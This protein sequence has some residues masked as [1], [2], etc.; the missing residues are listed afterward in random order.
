MSDF[1]D[2]FGQLSIPTNT[3]PVDPIEE[4][5]L[6]SSVATAA[7][8]VLDFTFI[9][10]KRWQRKREGLSDD[11][12]LGH[13]ARFF[14]AIVVNLPICAGIAHLYRIMG[15]NVQDAYLIG[16]VLWL[17]VAIP[18]LMT[19]R[20]MEDEHKKFLSIRILGW[21]LKTAAAATAAAYFITLR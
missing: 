2:I 19:S 12:S 15:N 14:V 10:L 8:I 6:A 3:R 16:A 7:C 13:V 21:L 17:F 11:D 1:L 4:I 18:L 5:V 20:Y 9:A